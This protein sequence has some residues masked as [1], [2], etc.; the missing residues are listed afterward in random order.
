MHIHTTDQELLSAMR[1]QPSYT[2]VDEM[3]AF[4]LNLERSGIVTHS[5]VKKAVADFYRQTP[6]SARGMVERRMSH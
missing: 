5:Q 6:E 4:L 2:K 1:R 3:I